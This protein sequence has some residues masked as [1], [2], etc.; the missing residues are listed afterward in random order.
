MTLPKKRPSARAKSRVTPQKTPQ[1]RVVSV[2]LSQ[3]RYEHLA[4]SAQTNNRTVEQ[5]A[6]YAIGQHLYLPEST[7]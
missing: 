6:H 4:A 7:P 2:L 3:E 5:E 1:A